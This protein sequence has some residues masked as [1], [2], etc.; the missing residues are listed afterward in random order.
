MMPEIAVAL[1]VLLFIFIIGGGLMLAGW[2]FGDSDGGDAL[3]KYIF[4]KAEILSENA[5][6]DREIKR[7]A[8]NLK[9]QEW[10]RAS[11]EFTANR[12]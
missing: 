1:T 9:E 10:A 3:A 6:C 12:Q 4:T 11:A 7:S 8:Q 5:K 2:L